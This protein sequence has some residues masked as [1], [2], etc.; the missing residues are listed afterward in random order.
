V[1]AYA[2]VQASDAGDAAFEQIENKKAAE[3]LG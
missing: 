2:T 3:K 1:R